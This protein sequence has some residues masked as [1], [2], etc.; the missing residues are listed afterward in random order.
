M[1]NII[2]LG[3]PGSGKG[4]Q[5]EYIVEQFG[6]SH[7]STGDCLRKEITAQSEL[8]KRVKDIMSKGELVS[9]EIVNAIIANHIQQNQDTKGFLFDGYPRTQA[10]AEFLDKKLEEFNIP[11][12]FC[13]NLNVSDDELVRR[14]VYRGQLSGRSDDT[15]DTARE[16]INVYNAKTKILLDY[17]GKQDKVVDIDGHGSI[18]ETNILVKDAIQSNK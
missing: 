11:I 16:R 14:I 3:P 15:E 4:T 17:Y 8:G 10:Q 2:L 1:L 18:E 12:T 13:I 7:I 9:D 5:A 6:I